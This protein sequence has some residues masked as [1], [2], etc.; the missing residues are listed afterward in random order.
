MTVLIRVNNINKGK[1][2]SAD[3]IPKKRQEID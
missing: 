1:V 2:K 3:K